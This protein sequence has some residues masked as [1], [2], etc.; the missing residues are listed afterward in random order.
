M[1]NTK[2]FTSPTYQAEVKKTAQKEKEVFRLIQVKAEKLCDMSLIKNS[3]TQLSYLTKE[4]QTGAI[5]IPKGL[6]LDKL[7]A[8]LQRL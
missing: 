2:I 5:A 3:H 6:I 7:I 1:L 4:E 8:I